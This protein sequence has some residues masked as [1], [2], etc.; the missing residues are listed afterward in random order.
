VRVLPTQ[1]VRAEER[2]RQMKAL[3]G[4]GLGLQ[5]YQVAVS[6]EF[7]GRTCLIAMRPS[8]WGYSASK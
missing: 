4:D 1:K 6:S 3:M 2:T 5:L 7:S 8:I